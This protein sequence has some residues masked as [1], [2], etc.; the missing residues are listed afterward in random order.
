MEELKITIGI[1]VY[2]NE[3]VIASRIENIL[4][5]TYQNFCIIISDNNST[6]K[7]KK[8]CD[9]LSELDERI[10]FI[11]HEKNRGAYWNFNFLLQK[12][13]TKYFVVAASDDIWSK[14]FLEKNIDIL[15][16]NKEVVGSISECSLFNRKNSSSDKIE[17]NVIKNSKEYEYVHPIEGKLEH[18]IKFCLKYNMG[19]QIYSIFRTKDIQSSNF[20]KES[21]NHGMWQQDLATILTILKKGNLHVDLKSFFYK[22][23]DIRSHSIIKYMKIMN[24]STRDIIFAKIIFSAW[25]LREFGRRSFLQNFV[26][27]MKYNFSW[28]KTIFGETLRMSKRSILGQ[29]RYW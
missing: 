7:T 16:K 28:G 27:L 18:K 4:S 29:N 24:Y 13:K 23:V 11:S 8:I 1:P 10:T 9:D 12:A 6:D 25:F 3:D 19:G 2:N 15:E 14:N 21:G 22:E 17:I 20:Y 26:S 5:Q